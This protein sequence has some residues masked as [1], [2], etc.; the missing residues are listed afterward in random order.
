MTIRKATVLGA[1]TMGSQIAA[2][3]VNAGLKVKLLDI[4]IDDN[5]PNKISKKAYETITNKKRP[6]LFNLDYASNLTYGNFNEDLAHD[7]ADIYIEA[8]KEDVDVKHKIWQQVQQHAK[9]GAIFATNTSGIPIESIAQAFNDDTRQRFLGLHFF[10]PPRI[11]KLAEI[12]PNE[13]T[14]NSVIESVKSFAEE[15]LGKGTVVANDVAGFVANRVGTQ[16]MNDVMY[17]AEQQGFS[18]TEVDALTGRAIGRPNTGTYGLTDLV[19]LDI[20]QTVTEG[21]RRVPEEQPYFKEVQLSKKLFEAGAL[22]RKTKQGFYKKENKKRLVLDPE[23]N[24]YVEPQQPTFDILGRFSKD[25]AHNLDVIFNAT[26][27]A[28]KFLWET[29]R[30]NFYYSAINVPKA[31]ADFKDIDRAIVWG[32]NWKKGPFQLWDLMGFDRVKDRIKDEIGD[33]PDWV[34]KQQGSFYAENESIERVTDVSNF[35]D[36]EIWNKD[37][38]NLS[39]A[40]KDQLLLKLQSKNNV[41][42]N[43]FVEDLNDAIDTLENGDYTSMVIYADGNNF[44]VGANLYMMKKA[45][46]DGAVE[47]E[48]K[49]AVERLHYVFSRLKYALKPIVTATQGKTLGGGCEL[50]MHSPFVVAYSETYIGLVETGVGL[51]PSGGGLAELATRVLSAD[52]QKDDKQATMAK[53]LMNIGLAKVATNAHE[54]VRY[55]YLKET[56]TIIM[57]KEKRIEIALKRARYESETN[58]MPAPKENF[59]ALGKDFKALAQGQLDAQR[60]GHFISDYDYEITLKIADILAGGD[61]PRNT[62]VNQ[63]YLQNLEKAG[64]VELLQ[65]SKTYDRISHMLKTGKPLRN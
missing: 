19:G 63:R 46:E 24:E 56:D 1:G 9:E 42:T 39:V 61:L 55:G 45:H 54:A 7:D 43:E 37:D 23:K 4:V 14:A 16:S 52:H 34:D 2:L 48:V 59:I 51:L 44:S 65:N 21:M 13:H 22:G 64:F 20:A 29:L 5:D 32:F 33:L 57:N 28:G 31:A 17:R 30:N 40:N 60:L 18:I 12:I 25:L 15:I 41:I 3:F 6:M 35:I 58:Y 47:T 10:N 27:D 38:S 53:I 49:P 8:V 62:Y 26:D 11:M 36:S 50:V